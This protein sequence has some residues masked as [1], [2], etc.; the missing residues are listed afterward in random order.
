MSN[1]N[2]DSRLDFILYEN[3]AILLT[4]FL[5]TKKS[6]LKNIKL[7]FLFWKYFS[8]IHNFSLFTFNY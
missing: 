3:S 8:K 2:K 7:K 5:K 1:K 4:T 6:I